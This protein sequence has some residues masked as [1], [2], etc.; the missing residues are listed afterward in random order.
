MCVVAVSTSS[1]ISS[2]LM[3]SEPDDDAARSGFTLNISGT[4]AAE[5]IYHKIVFCS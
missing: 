2:S 1:D 3:V 4:P 5:V